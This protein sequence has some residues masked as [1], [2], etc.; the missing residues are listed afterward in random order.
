MMMVCDEGEVDKSGCLLV[1]GSSCYDNDK[2]TNTEVN[3]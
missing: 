1:A 2:R 3:T